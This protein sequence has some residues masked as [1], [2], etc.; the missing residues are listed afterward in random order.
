MDNSVLSKSVAINGKKVKDN[1]L[2]LQYSRYVLLRIGSSYFARYKIGKYNGIASSL[3]TIL[4][5]W[6]QD[7][8]CHLKMSVT[9]DN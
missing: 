7:K 4:K 3:L 2:T 9:M 8:L 5:M 6:Q 1:L